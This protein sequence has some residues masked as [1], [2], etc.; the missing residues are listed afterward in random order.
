MQ[1]RTLVLL[2]ATAAGLYLCARMAGPFLPAGAWALALAVLFAPL[3]RRLESRLKRPSAAA[4]VSVLVIGLIVVV[5]ATFVAQQLA[6]QA[7]KGA[8]LFEA[9]FGSGEWRHALDAQP[10]LALLA[11]TIQQRVDLPGLV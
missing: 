3:Q 5:P 11:E 9:K 4:L 1:L 2:L 7:A 6:V 8:T 10:R